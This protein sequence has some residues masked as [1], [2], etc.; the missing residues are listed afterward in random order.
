MEMVQKIATMKK[1]LVFDGDFMHPLREYNEN[2]PYNYK[3]ELSKTL[4]KSITI[5]VNKYDKYTAISD[6]ERPNVLGVLNDLE[7]EGISLTKQIAGQLNE[8]IS[9]IY[10]QSLY[11]HRFLMSID[12]DGNEMKI[13]NNNL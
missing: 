9:K 4:I 2:I 6:D 3:E 11:S 5:W 1:I 13:F 10:Y 8:V 7:N 12:N